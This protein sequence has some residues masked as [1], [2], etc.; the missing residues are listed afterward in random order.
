MAV[1][2]GVKVIPLSAEATRQSQFTHAAVINY[3]TVVA[4]GGA[5]TTAV[6]VIGDIAAG[7]V[8]GDRIAHVV[9]EA[10][11]DSDASLNSIIIRVGET[12]TD[13]F[14][15]DQEIGED[16]TEVD[17]FHSLGGSTGATST[18][19]F[20]FASA[21]TLDCL[22]T[23]AGGANPTCAELTAGQVVIFYQQFSLAKLARGCV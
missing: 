8:I 18:A 9:T 21:D 13:R 3:S 10:W 17:Y 4:I 16:G 7:D 19:P 14:L 20:A 5:A 11:T 6:V 2:S 23:V 22:F 12:D 1:S 15:T